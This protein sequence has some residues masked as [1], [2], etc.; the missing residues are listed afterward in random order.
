MGL[1]QKIFAERLRLVRKASGLT[2]AA[3]AEM[4]GVKRQA[5]VNLET[6]QRSPAADTLYD[7]AKATGASVDYLL[8]L[9]GSGPPSPAWAADLLPDLA[10]LDHHG[11]EAVKVLVKGLAKGDR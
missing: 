3:L 9:P 5:I 6:G 8:G 4:I 2:G 7:L 11:Q 10:A 1:D